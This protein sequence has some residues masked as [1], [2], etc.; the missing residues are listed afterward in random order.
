MLVQ[1]HQHVLL[2]LGHAVVDGN[3]V[4]VSVEAVDECLDRWLVEVTDVRGRLTWL[5][6]CHESLWVDEA[7]SIDDDLAFDGLDWVHDDCYCAWVEL[8]ERLLCVDINGREPASETWM[9]MVPSNHGLWAT[10]AS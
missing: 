5:L 4:V 2:Q 10:G 6:A 1:V 3:A 8:L 9:G 7:E